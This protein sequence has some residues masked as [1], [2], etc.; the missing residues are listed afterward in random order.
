MEGISIAPSILD[1]CKRMQ[2]S[3]TYEAYKPACNSN[4]LSAKALI[5]R[6]RYRLLGRC[7]PNVTL[8]GEQPLHIPLPKIQR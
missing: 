7:K 4:K 3:G 5:F 8:S 6:K 2:S 1:L